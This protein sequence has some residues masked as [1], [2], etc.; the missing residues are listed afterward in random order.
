VRPACGGIGFPTPATSSSFPTGKAVY[1][2]RRPPLACASGFILPRACRLSRVLPLPVGPAPPSVEPLPWGSVPSSRHQ[3]AASMPPGSHTRQPC[4]PRRFSRPRR[5]TPP[6]AWW[7]YFTPQPRPGFA[8]QGFPLTHSRNTSSVPSALS[9][10][11]EGSLLSVTQ[12]RHASSPRPQGFPLCESALQN[13]TE[14][15]RR[16]CSLPS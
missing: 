7:V 15:I 11:S 10:F 3:P 6:L 14:I 4:R 1:T 16:T 8:L 9:S 12:Q 13:T 5:F 2:G